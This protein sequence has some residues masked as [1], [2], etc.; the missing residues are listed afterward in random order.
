MFR[1]LVDTQRIEQLKEVLDKV[2]LKSTRFDEEHVII[3]A[4]LK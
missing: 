4:S 1:K 2:T 3:K